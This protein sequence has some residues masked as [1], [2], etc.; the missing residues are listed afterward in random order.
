MECGQIERML[1]GYL[2]KALL[3]EEM[4]R[5]GKHLTSCAKCRMAF[6]DYKKARVL[7]RN[8]EDV[9]PPP[10]FAQKIMAQVREEDREK[11]GL[12]KKLFYPIHIKVPI[13]AVATVVIAMLAIQ[14]Y[15]SV[16]PQKRAIQPSAVS[17]PAV[18]APVAPKEEIRQER[19]QEIAP[20]P[21]AESPRA[22]DNIQLSKERRSKDKETELLEV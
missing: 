15:R 13:Q 20:S 9:A 21:R 4:A 8:L 3:P 5:V 17:A 2:E 14:V 12:L 18:S 7:V 19:K 11:G 10:G 22:H 1:P 16:E 6:E